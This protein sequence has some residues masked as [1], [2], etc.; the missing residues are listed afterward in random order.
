MKHT[1]PFVSNILNDY[2]TGSWQYRYL[3]GV[4]GPPASGKSTLAAELPALINTALGP[5][6][7]TH[8]SMDAYHYP[9]AFLHQKGIYPHKGCH[10]TFDVQRFLAKLIEI[11]EQP[12]T[13]SCPI[14]DRSRGHDPI[15]DE[16]CIEAHHRLVVVEG[17]YLL[18]RIHPWIAIRHLLEYCLYIE[19]DPAV[20]FPRLLERHL[21]S[22]RT[23][24]D[25]RAKIIRTDL[26]NAELI[27]RH[28]DRA[29]FVWRPE[30][31]I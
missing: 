26:P 3:V 8:F 6:V 15:P 30:W 9:N 16:H 13:V 17:N 22:G 24:E 11:K 28:K 29:N 14:Y 4:V 20:Q 1:Y 23:E 31:N 2:R 27:A 10:F 7:A 19:V 12:G 18:L 21:K 5:E 25:A